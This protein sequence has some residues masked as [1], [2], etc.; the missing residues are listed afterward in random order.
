MNKFSTPGVEFIRN[1]MDWDK[2]DPWGCARAASFDLAEAFWHYS[3]LGLAGFRPSP[4]LEQEEMEE[5]SRVQRIYEG[6]KLG[7]VELDDIWYWL[8]VTNRME[9]LIV[10]AGRAY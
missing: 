5:G 2:Y 1:E 3:G 8:K 4:L 9:N 6:M 10:D 7:V